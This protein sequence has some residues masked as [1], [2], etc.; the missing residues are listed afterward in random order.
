METGLASQG[1][2][3]RQVGT[4]GGLAAGNLDRGIDAVV[5]ANDVEFTRDG[6]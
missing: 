1:D 2:D 5:V 3:C 4:N 6:L